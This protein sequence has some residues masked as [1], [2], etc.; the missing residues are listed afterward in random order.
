MLNPA[1]LVNLL[2][3]PFCVGGRCTRFGSLALIHAEIPNAPACTNASQSSAQKCFT[4]P[5][6][7]ARRARPPAKRVQE[8]YVVVNLLFPRSTRI[9]MRTVDTFSL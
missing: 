8:G 7:H 2:V 6:R 4:T 3:S 9:L 1:L 5:L